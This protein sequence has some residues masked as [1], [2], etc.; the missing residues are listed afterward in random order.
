MGS[1]P[2]IV[3][4]LLSSKEPHIK[5]LREIDLTILD[6]GLRAHAISFENFLQRKALAHGL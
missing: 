5:M 6:P 4:E 2:E 1:N 3:K